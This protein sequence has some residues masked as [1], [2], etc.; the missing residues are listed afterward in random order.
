MLDEE[1]E[2]TKPARLNEFLLHMIMP[3]MKSCFHT[4]LHQGNKLNFIKYSWIRGNHSQI[5]L[6]SNRRESIFR[7][8]RDQCNLSLLHGHH[9]SVKPIYNLL[10]SRLTSYQSHPCICPWHLTMIA[11]QHQSEVLHWVEWLVETLTLHKPVQGDGKDS[12]LALLYC[13]NPFVPSLY[14]LAYHWKTGTATNN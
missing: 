1:V 12:I 7:C 13:Y 9:C 6:G 11:A 5:Q 14:H 2:F 3:T 10:C 8:N 4:N